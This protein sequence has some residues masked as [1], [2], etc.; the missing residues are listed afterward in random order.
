MDRAAV[1]TRVSTDTQKNNFSQEYQYETCK[2]YSELQGWKIYGHYHDTQTGTDYLERK[3]VRDVLALLDS[4]LI[5]HVVFMA[6]DRVGRESEVIKSF[7][8]AIYDRD[9][10]V[11]IAG[12]NRTY[13]TYNECVAAEIWNIAM[14]ESE[15][16]KIL[17]R[18]QP[19]R[20]MAFK[21]GSYAKKAPYGYRTVSKTVDRQKFVYLEIVESDAATIRLALE[22]YSRTR[23]KS[24]TLR[25]MNNERLSFKGNPH[26]LWH[27]ETLK[28]LLRDTELYTGNPQK[29]RYIPQ[30]PVSKDNPEIEYTYPPII[31]REL[32][33][34]VRIANSL[35]DHKGTDKPAKDRPFVGLVSCTCGRKALLESSS[36]LAKSGFYCQSR[37][38]NKRVKTTVRNL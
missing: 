3:A 10:Y 9:G 35:N 29:I 16:L 13:D 31:S 5:E 32:A 28:R 25:Y 26:T 33:D 23:S 20:L 11:S 14:A 27:S 12:S 30:K 1:V 38:H 21:K 6:I 4:K 19:S 18:T 8:K 37:F 24:A 2:R 22:Y 17:S 7:I 36:S 34:R 15:R